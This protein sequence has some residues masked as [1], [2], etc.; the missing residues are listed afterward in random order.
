[1]LNSKF[2][3]RFGEIDLVMKEQATIVF[4]EVKYRKN[5]L[6]GGAVSA[7]TPTKQQKIIK[8]AA[9]YLQQCGLKEYNTACRFDVIAVTGGANYPEI[10][11]L[12]NAFYEKN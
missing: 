2:H 5:D 11:W 9:F 3:C 10:T 8:T 6:F 4:I 7:I 1:M 12:K